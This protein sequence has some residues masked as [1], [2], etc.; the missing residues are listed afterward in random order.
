MTS[1][2][3]TTGDQ[4]K[5]SNG[6]TTYLTKI[7]LCSNGSDDP[8]DKHKLIQRK[9]GECP[10][11]DVCK[12]CID[13]DKVKFKILDIHTPLTG[14]NAAYMPTTEELIN[15]NAEAAQEALTDA[16]EVTDMIR[17]E[18][19]LFDPTSSEQDYELKAFANKK[20]VMKYTFQDKTEKV[21]EYSVCGDFKIIEADDDAETDYSTADLYDLDTS[22][23]DKGVINSVIETEIKRVWDLH[24]DAS[25][26]FDTFWVQVGE[27]ST[28]SYFNSYKEDKSYEADA[29]M[30]KLSNSEQPT[31]K[32]TCKRTMAYTNCE[33]EAEKCKELI[34]ESVQKTPYENIFIPDRDANG[35]L[36][37]KCKRVCDMKD[38]KTWVDNTIYRQAYKEWEMIWLYGSNSEKANMFK[39]LNDK[40]VT[41]FTFC[42]PICPSNKEFDH[43]MLKGI[44]AGT[45]DEDL[46]CVKAECSVVTNGIITKHDIKP[47][48]IYVID[49]SGDSSCIT[50]CPTGYVVD[51]VKPENCK[52]MCKIGQR[53]YYDDQGD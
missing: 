24:V 25:G 42:K 5:N 36:T 12:L 23:T 46:P 35:G 6:I 7:K 41:N 51:M 10:F 50:N 28:A 49:D 26:T 30:W 4:C 2:E 8:L 11:K 21:T 17:F 3:T 19:Y 39:E 18:N 31:W 43:T 48:Q 20:I 1:D 45:V 52:P 47:N 29:T 37:W 14:D 15:Q 40:I 34:M 16:G 38:G 9:F 32:L 44:L 33:E 13:V 22:R 53:T 27:N